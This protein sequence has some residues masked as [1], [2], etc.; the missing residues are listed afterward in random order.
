MRRDL[1]PEALRAGVMEPVSM[2]VIDG[3]EQHRR[4][5][6]L[7]GAAAVGLGK[8]AAED[9][10]EERTLVRVCPEPETGRVQRLTQREAGDL[11]QTL[12][13]AVEGGATVGY[14]A[15]RHDS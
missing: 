3:A 2:R 8:P 13:L 7:D 6:A 9:E 11:T 15:A 5:P 1:D 4:R 12:H 10:A 14:A